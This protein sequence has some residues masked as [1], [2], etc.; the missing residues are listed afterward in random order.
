MTP[1]IW[2]RATLTA[3]AVATLTLGLGACAPLVVGG[4]ATGVIVAADRRTSGAQ[5]EDEGIELRAANRLREAL[6]DRGN[7][8]VTSYN[9]QVLLTGEVPTEDDRLKAEQIL[10]K[11]D[12]VRSVLNEL[13]VMPAT[14]LSQRSSDALVTGRVKASVVDAQD[15]STHAFKVLTERGTVYLMGRVTEREAKRVTDIART[16]QGSKRV[17]RA[18][19]IISEEELARLTPKPAATPPAAKPAGD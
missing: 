17:V 3:L 18:F 5:L 15:L 2:Q 10:S 19:E 1:M 14:S 13:A 4:V 9:R 6:G 11:V 16:V 7:V 8:N 12:N